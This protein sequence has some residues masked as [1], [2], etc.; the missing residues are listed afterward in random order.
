MT[1][2]T[3]A[4]RPPRHGEP[5]EDVLD[6]VGWT[7]LIR[8]NRVTGGIRTPVY[9]KAEFMNPGGSVKDRI[10]LAMIEAAERAGL[11]EPGRVQTAPGAEAE[12]TFLARAAA[13]Q[14]WPPAETAVTNLRA[15]PDESDLSLTLSWDPPTYETNFQIRDYR[16]RIDYQKWLTVSSNARSVLL[17]ATFDSINPG[18]RHRFQVRARFGTRSNGFAGRKAT[19][20]ETA[21]GGAVSEPPALPFSLS[22]EFIGDIVHLTWT[23]SSTSSEVLRWEVRVGP[24]GQWWST[25]STRPGWA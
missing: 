1:G 18:Q 21:P 16:Y 23:I 10:G 15:E 4:G 19:I 7:P 2:E 3:G 6:L 17:D 20:W 24:N 13:S 14:A 8:L 22:H 9:G 11:L 12:D 5:Y 25:N